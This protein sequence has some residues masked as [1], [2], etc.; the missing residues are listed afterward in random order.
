[1]AELDPVQTITVFAIAAFFIIW[2]YGA[3]VYSRRLAARVARELKDAV[4]ALGGT[5]QIRWFGTGAFRMTTEGATAPFREFSVTVTLRPREMPIN[6]AIGKAQRRQDA[7]LVEAS[8]QKEPKVAFE[9][10]DPTTRIGQRR[11]RAQSVWSP[12]TI[13]ARNWLLAADDEDRVRRLLES[14]G[15]E[16]LLTIM[17]LHVSAGSTPGVAASISV[18]PT[19]AAQGLTTIRTLANRLVG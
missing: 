18:K 3:F 9:L 7:A 13:G 8:L 4:L 5:S 19:D 2:Y 1:V 17:A 15:P 12:V 6:W 10:V 16:A 14:L 11:K